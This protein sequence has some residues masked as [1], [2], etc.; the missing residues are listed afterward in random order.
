V[1]L[2][3]GGLQKKDVRRRSEFFL[4]EIMNEGRTMNRG[5]RRN[6]EMNV[7]NRRTKLK[8]LKYNSYLYIFVIFI[9]KNA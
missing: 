6:E 7:S 2:R 8:I 5:D 9:T 1:S 4:E 3:D